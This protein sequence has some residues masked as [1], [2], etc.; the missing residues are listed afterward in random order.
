MA[1]DLRYPALIITP[2][3]DD[4]Q[5]RV[6]RG[7]GNPRVFADIEQSQKN[8][9]RS[10]DM[11]KADLNENERGSQTIG[12]ARLKIRNEALAKSYRPVETFTSET[13]PFI[14]DLDETGELLVLVS[15]TGLDRLSKKVRT[16]GQ[17]G[18]AHLTSVES[19]SLVEKERRFPSRV[20]SAVLDKIQRRGQARL[21]VRIP[22]LHIFASLFRDELEDQKLKLT[23]MGVQ[24][25]PYL[26]QGNF[27]IYAVQV[28]SMEEAISLASLS[29]VDRLELMPT[30]T[31][32]SSS[33]IRTAGLQLK[34]STPFE[35]LPIVAIVDTGI[36]PNSPLEPLIYD[37]QTHVLS[38]H[39]NPSHGTSVAALAAASGGEVGAVLIPRCRLLDIAIIPNGDKDAGETDVIDEDRLVRKIEEAVEEYSADVKYWNLSFSYDPGYQPTTFSDLG[40]RLDDLHKE[41]G[42]TFVCAAGN[43]KLLRKQWPPDLAD[44][45]ESWVSAPGDTVCGIT[46]GSCTDDNTFDDTFAQKG[47]PSSFSPRGPVAYGVIKPD[48]LEVGGNLTADGLTEIGVST[49]QRNGEL[50]SI[51]GTS[52]STPRVCGASA[53][54]NTYIKQNG[55]DYTNS[56]LT[57]AL[58][59][60]HAKIPETFIL[61]STLRASDY[62]GY[63]KPSSLQDTI[64]DHFWRSTT[65]ICGKL[66]PDRED[67][68]IDDFP[69][70]DDLCSEK[71]SQG[72]VFITMVS[73][74]VLDSSFK[75]EYIRSNV[76][77]R[78]GTVYQETF[79]GQTTKANVGNEISL[80]QEEHKWSPIKQYRTPSRMNCL[81]NFWR[82]NVSLS[83]REKESSIVRGDKS[84]IQD[85]PVEVVI[86]VTIADPLHRVQVNSQVLRKWRMRGYVPTQIEAASRLRAQSIRIDGKSS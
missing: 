72:Q 49:I 48:L 24:E 20:Q 84:K 82:L 2:H 70:P 76:D 74:P 29:F 81:G 73:D 25:T 50:C 42:V 19:F 85:Y 57:K 39:Y 37:R 47:T 1:D 30:Y 35:D 18:A 21:K 16:L 61:G 12:L 43:S 31:S 22:S 5:R 78:F 9:L 40:I 26:H 83:L 11:I 38:P 33:V 27:E 46:V 64:G 54:M 60:H 7:G 62:Y 17:T 44:S 14:G 77:V 63:G 6:V 28:S 75:T 34:T 86:A 65:L 23:K 32:S 58:M 79:R 8:M 68:V 52:F 66:Y 69:Y 53:E 4:Y 45:R 13:C 15:A 10:C 59:L 55:G 56:L 67:I 3:T 71:Y 41:Y 51:A 80:I 36:D